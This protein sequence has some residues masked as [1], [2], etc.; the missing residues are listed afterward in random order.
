MSRQ[1]YQAYNSQNFQQIPPTSTNY[2][3]QSP[4]ATLTP[5]YYQ[6]PSLS[7]QYFPQY[8][9]QPA[10]LYTHESQQYSPPHNES[11]LPPTYVT[12]NSSDLSLA[13]SYTTQ[14]ILSPEYIPHNSD[15][16][17]T[18][19]YTTQSYLTPEYIPKHYV[20]ENDNYHKP[21]NRL[22]NYYIDDYSDSDKYRN[23]DCCVII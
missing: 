4:S 13:Q 18:Q 2:F 6:P 22:D 16:S 20:T 10:Y 11:Q 19:S 5:Y 15:S 8:E 7:S 12:Q 21:E 9:Q 1:D 3:L 17:S 23:S 14:S